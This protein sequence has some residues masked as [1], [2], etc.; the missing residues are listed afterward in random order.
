MKKTLLLML[1]ALV[2]VGLMSPSV[3]KAQQRNVTFIINTATV[4]DTI[5]SRRVDLHYRR[6]AIQYVQH[7]LTGW[8][9]G[10]LLTNIGGRLL[11]HDARVQAGRHAVYKIRIYPTA[12]NSGWE[13]NINAASQHQP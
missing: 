4:P 1:V 6:A 3:L 10:A 9:T 8:G 13:E 5:E 7:A 2:A 12:Q 11:V